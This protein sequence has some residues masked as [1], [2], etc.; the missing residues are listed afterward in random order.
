M[1][2][3]PNPEIGKELHPPPLLLETGTY[4]PQRCMTGSALAAIV[5]HGRAKIGKNAFDLRTAHVAKAGSSSAHRRLEADGPVEVDLESPAANLFDEALATAQK[6]AE[7][8]HQ[9]GVLESNLHVV[10]HPHRPLRIVSS[11]RLM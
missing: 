6:L 3:L 4:R 8:G 11:A 1:P 2:G 10:P 9:C 5:T 7:V